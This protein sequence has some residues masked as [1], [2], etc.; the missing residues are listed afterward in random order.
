M[1]RAKDLLIK[2]ITSKAAA[3]ICKSIHYSGKV[4]QNSQVHLGVFLDGKCGGVMQFGPPMDRNRMAGLVR[5]TRPREMIELNRMA[6]AEWLPRNGE[7]RAL[8]VAMRLLRDRYPHLKWVVSF[9]D[10][11]QCGDGTIYRAA[12]FA[13]TGIKKNASL[14]RMPDGTVMAKKSLDD[15]IDKR[16]G[17]YGSVAAVRSGAVPLV[18]FQLRY[19]YFLHKAERCNLVPNEIPFSEIA[20]VGAGMYRGEKRAASI[21]NDASGFQPG[22][23]GEIPTAA[24]HSNEAPNG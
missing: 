11:C 1:G 6:F 13:L 7:S 15:K 12:G 24:L 14:L 5:G 19:V 4:V 20:R 9:A 8:G 16:S 17:A 23:G 18:G 10:G 2:P 21:G 22:E 3:V